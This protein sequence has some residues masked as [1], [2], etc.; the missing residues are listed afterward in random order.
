MSDDLAGEL[1]KSLGQQLAAS[2]PE[3]AGNADVAQNMALFVVRILPALQPAVWVMIIVANLYLALRLTAASGKLRRPKDDWPRALRMPRPAL[4]IFA[5]ACAACFLPGGIGYAATA[6]CRRASAPASL[7]AGFA[8]LPCNDTR[9]TMAP[10]RAM[11]CIPRRSALCLRALPLPSGRFVRHVAQR[12]GF[13]GC[14]YNT[15]Q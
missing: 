4:I 9:C 11:D 10:G 5:V 1:A 13:E 2:N 7:M 3:L 8:M 15:T 6:I 12:T 14:A